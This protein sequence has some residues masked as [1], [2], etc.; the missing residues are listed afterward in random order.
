MPDGWPE[1][2]INVVTEC[3][4]P[5][6][7]GPRVRR[8]RPPLRAVARVITSAPLRHEEARPVPAIRPR[9]VDLDDARAL[10]PRSDRLDRLVRSILADPGAFGGEASLAASARR[11][12]RR[13]TPLTHADL[14]AEAFDLLR[15]WLGGPLGEQIARASANELGVGWSLLWPK[16]AGPAKA[17]VFQGRAEFFTRDQ[18]GAWRAVV[19]SVPGAPEPVERLR[20]L[21]SA[22]AS[23]SLGY[24]PVVQ[25]WHV[26]LGDGLRGED[27]FDDDVIGAAIR[28]VVGALS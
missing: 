8:L 20:L 12:S 26:R 27:A 16:D 19:F 28:Q 21:L 4:P 10:S 15:P 14:E 9:F 2:S 17:T 6:A 1:P 22:R 5:A 11:A 18:A 7:T 24:R 23:E 13:Q 25:G 3:P